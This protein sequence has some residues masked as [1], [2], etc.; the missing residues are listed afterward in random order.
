[1]TSCFSKSTGLG[2]M[3]VRVAM[4]PARASYP[5]RPGPASDGAAMASRQQ[6]DW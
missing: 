2:L 1:M 4:Y 5:A 3:L 6:F